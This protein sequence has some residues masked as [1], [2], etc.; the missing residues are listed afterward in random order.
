MARELLELFEAAKKA[1]DAAAVEE[2]PA[3][4]SR[5]LDAL[6]RL[7]SFP[8]TKQDLID[9]QIGKRVRNLKKHPREKIQALA[10]DLIEIWKRVVLEES[11][12]NKQNGASDN[13]ESPK[14]EVA[15]LEPVKAEKVQNPESIKV[16]KTEKAE[17][18]E[19]LKSERMEKISRAGSFKTEKREAVKVEKI[20]GVENAK[21]EKLSK[22]EKQASGIKKPLQAS[23]GPPKLTTM[24]KSNDAMRDKIRDILAE[25]FSKVSTEADED[26][27]DE[28]DACDPIRVAISV[29]SVLFGKWGRSNGAHKV[30]YRSIMFNI[31]DPKNPDFRRR[32]LL[33][34]VK[35]ESLL[36]MT[37]EEM[38][39]D[40]RR[41]QNEQIKEKALFECERGGPPKATTDQFKCGRCGQRKC[42]YY[43]MQTRSADEPMTTFVTCVNCNH[44]WKFC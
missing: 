17:R 18:G 14:A 33:G 26:V 2:S 36:S 34:Q 20:D 38:A 39:S 43:Q 25:A 8:V 12:K 15:K 21:I 37:P 16:E 7:K 29:E 40:Q 30:K 31:N 13:K 9:T 4:E 22:E 41:R 5:C 23:N 1:A 42:T 10:S 24:I 35:P 28:V 44:H 27:R 19:T 11:A 6:K 3:E 32:V